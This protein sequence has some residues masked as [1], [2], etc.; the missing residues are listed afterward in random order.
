MMYL[1][2]QGSDAFLDVDLT[3][4]MCCSTSLEMMF[5]NTDEC[6]AGQHGKQR[7]R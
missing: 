2:I 1:S 3:S 6:V 4:Q 7:E 5:T